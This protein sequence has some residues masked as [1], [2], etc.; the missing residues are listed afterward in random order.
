MLVLSQCLNLAILVQVGMGDF[1][2]N[3][4]LA[5]TGLNLVLLPALVCSS[6][7]VCLRGLLF[8]NFLVPAPLGPPP[9]SRN[10]QKSGVRGDPYSSAVGQ[11]GAVGIRP[12]Y[13]A[14]GRTQ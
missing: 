7:L 11:L 4:F 12:Y 8:G 13:Q 3:T 14:A 5:A 6:A 2:L 1:W 10:V 9:P